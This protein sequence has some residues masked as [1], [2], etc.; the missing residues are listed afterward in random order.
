[1]QR[2]L[3]LLS[4]MILLFLFC[5]NKNETAELDHLKGIILVINQENAELKDQINL[6]DEKYKEKTQ[7]LL[8]E[9]K[10]LKSQLDDAGEILKI[11]QNIDKNGYLKQN[12]N[13]D[14]QILRTGTFHGNE[15]SNDAAKKEWFGLVKEKDGY[16]LKRTKIKIDITRDIIIDEEG[17][18][19]GKIVS[20]AD[21]DVPV[22]LIN[23]LKG[24]AEGPVKSFDLINDQLYP[25]EFLS[26][27]INK[28]WI[29]VSAHGVCNPGESLRSYM[30]QI[31]LQDNQKANQIFV[32]SDMFDDA[33]F[34]FLWAGDID[35]DSMLDL[36]IDTSSHYNVSQI[37]LFLSSMADEG[38]LIKQVAM[39]RTVG[40]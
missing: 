12:I 16:I 13:T 25:G 23:G 20:A 19:S 28:R 9:N 4:L 22:I 40:C 26:F 27:K 1:M 30:L 6:L 21:I 17:E 24:I 31:S 29:N 15:I 35:Q 11:K 39:F 2:H 36:I 18:K 33:M 34:K 5:N 7:R 37:T 38:D 8:Q 14:I 32:G 10:E 3:L